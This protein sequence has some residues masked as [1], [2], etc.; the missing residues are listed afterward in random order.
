M[1]PAFSSLNL[2]FLGPLG[3]GKDTQAEVV[4]STYCIAHISTR[5]LLLEQIRRGTVGGE[6]IRRCL[7]DGLPVPDRLLAGL[8]L[9]RL[10]R[11]DCARG[12]L[13]TG[14]PGNLDQVGTLDGL[15]AELGRVIE[16]VVYFEVSDRTLL[17]RRRQQQFG[18][19]NDINPAAVS[20]ELAAFRRSI[21][22]VVDLYRARGLLMRVD[23][24]RPVHQVTAE[25]AQAVGMPVGA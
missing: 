18:G 17:L 10:D 4:A 6:Q 19:G 25:I 24:D 9:E 23:G 12:F 16:R 2:V 22:P 8:I 5:E 20:H 13:L 11:E 15:L 14:Y 21:R 1:S 7:E 3:S